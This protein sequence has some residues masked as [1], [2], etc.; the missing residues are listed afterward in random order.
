MPKE[1]DELVGRTEIA[2]RLGLSQNAVVGSWAG[3]YPDFPKPVEHVSGSYLL[4]YRWADV[5]EWCRK[6]GRADRVAGEP[7]SS[8]RRRSA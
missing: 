5:V 8:S 3:R 2:R 4:L 7:P 1:P 6:N